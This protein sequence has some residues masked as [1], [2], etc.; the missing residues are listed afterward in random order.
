M[1]FGPLIGF[2]GGFIF[3]WAK[4][5]PVNTRY[6]RKLVRDDTL[7]TLAGPVSNLLLAFA[8]FLGLAGMVLA[9]AQLSQGDSLLTTP[10]ALWT[11]CD[12]GIRVNLALFFFNLLPIPPLDGS[13]ILRHHLPYN[14]LSAYDSMGMFGYMLMI[15]VGGPIV[16]F[17][18]GPAIDLVSLILSHI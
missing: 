2:P 17:L 6:F 8:A 16:R 4:P 12:V 15:F 10:D 3:G 14:M 13:H 18:M 11:L 9:Q 7:V 1:I 5:T